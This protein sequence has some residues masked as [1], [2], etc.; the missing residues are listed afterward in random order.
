M[1]QSKTISTIELS[2]I[3]TILRVWPL[4]KIY[5]ENSYFLETRKRNVFTTCFN[6]GRSKHRGRHRSKIVINY[7][8][9]L[10]Q[11]YMKRLKR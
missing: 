8:F 9:K 10:K 6:I 7:K 11:T 5:S 2:S 1:N 3:S 4:T